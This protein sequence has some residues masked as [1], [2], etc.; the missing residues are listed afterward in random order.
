MRL[1]QRIAAAV[2]LPA[3]L[4][5]ELHDIGRRP[6]G[7]EARN[8]VQVNPATP[9]YFVTWAS[10]GATWDVAGKDVMV[11]LLATEVKEVFG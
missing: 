5:H 8:V 10:F 1:R 7:D 3:P 9:G 2:L 11:L 6:T 4:T